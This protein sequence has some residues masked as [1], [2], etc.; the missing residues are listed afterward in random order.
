[1]L[2]KSEN[3]LRSLRAEH[4]TLQENLKKEQNVSNRNLQRIKKKIFDHVRK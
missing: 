1:M 4:A 2:A 3:E